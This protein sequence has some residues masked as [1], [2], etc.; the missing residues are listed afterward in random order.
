MEI[1]KDS[2]IYTIIENCITLK[3]ETNKIIIELENEN[4]TEKEFNNFLNVM[5]S[6]KYKKEYEKE[7]L[8]VIINNDNLL[9]INN[10][11][12]II[13][14]CISNTLEGISHKWIK[15]NNK[16][17]NSIENFFDYNIKIKVIEE[18][19][20]IEPENWEENNKIYELH[21]KFKYIDDNETEYMVTMIKNDNENN[22]YNNLKDSNILKNKHIYKFEI[23]IYKN[24]IELIIASII[25]MIQA[26]TLMPIILTKEIQ[27]EILNEYHELIKKDIEI[28]IYN[29]RNEIPLLTPK[30]ITLEKINLINPDVYGSLSILREYTVTEKADGERLL[31][32][33][34][35]KRRKLGCFIPKTN[36]KVC[37]SARI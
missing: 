4:W 20:S 36:I 2:D 14:Y 28:T 5:N 7:E 34:V 6:L 12:N 25:K 18:I 26:I 10:K 30:P 33:I 29:K 37:F 3:D 31:M 17:N 11:S 19:K 35:C 23:I 32:Y 27:K 1:S 21:K 15:I 8:R 24:N 22:I 9:L 13:K 16:I